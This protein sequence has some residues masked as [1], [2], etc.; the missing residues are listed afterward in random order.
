[1]AALSDDMRIVGIRVHRRELP[2]VDG[3][4]RFGDTDINCL[5]STVVEVV[6]RSGLVGYG[7]T[8]PLGPTYQPH[9]ALGARAALAEMAPALIGHDARLI[10]LGRRLM[11]DV[12]AGHAY[13]KAAIDIALWDLLGKACGMRV[14]DLLGGTAHERVPSYYAIGVCEPDDGERLAAEKQAAGFRRIQLKVGG[15][16][17]EEDIEAIRKVSGALQPGV[18]L[19]VDANR[20][21]TVADAI[22]VSRLC[23]DLALVLEQPCDSPQ[24]NAALRGKVR[25]PVFLDESIE[26]LRV[27]NWAITQGVA[28]GFGLKLTRVGGL[29][30]FRAIRDTCD[31]YNIPHTCDDAWGGDV[32]AAACVHVAATVRPRLLEGAWIAAPYIREHYDPQ[33]PVRIVNGSIEVPSGV[34]LGVVPATEQWGPPVAQYG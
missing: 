22:T 34:G 3:P 4:Y 19:A 33:H 30:A 1:M 20:T 27:L 11:D 6:T 24:E 2:V 17:L 32:I 25:H 23:E 13:A 9:H 14:C 10:Q 12:L 28:Q 8:C 16:A 21:W 15:R 7:E 31:A 18:S 5:E 26:D 29:S